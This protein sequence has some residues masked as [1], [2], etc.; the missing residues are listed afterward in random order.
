MDTQAIT[1]ATTRITYEILERNK[2]AKDLVLIGILT[3]GKFLAQRIKEKMSQVEDDTDV[4]IGYLDI[5]NYRDDIEVFEKDHLDQTQIPFDITGKKVILVDDV[6]YT[7]RSIRAAIDGIMERGRPL[8]IQVAVLV[9]RGH[10]EI[11]IQADFVGK[12]LPTSAEEK[13]KVSLLE[14]DSEEKVAIYEQEGKA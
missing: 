14:F 1:R 3:R 12:N 4:P 2:G 8:N 13:V 10:R 11:P 6:L 7:G 9:D 5:Y